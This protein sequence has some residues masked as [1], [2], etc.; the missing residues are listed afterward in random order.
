MI[1]IVISLLSYF[2]PLWRDTS[3][4]AAARRGVEQYAKENYEEAAA[5]LAKAHELRPSPESAFN[6]GTAQIA[7]GKHAQG[8][9]TLEPALKDGKLAADALY[10]RGN[11][12]LAAGAFEYAVRDY[13]HAL[14]LHPGDRRAQRNLEIALRK[15]KEAQRPGAGG[16]DDQ[17]DKGKNERKT[18]STGGNQQQEQPK[19]DANLEAL[20]RSVQQ[21]EQE[22]RQRMKQAGQARERVG[23]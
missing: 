16:Q 1:V 14:K 23:W 13:T 8:S 17:K 12:A 3:S 2:A 4:N 22:E 15:Q 7:A 9:A 11:S 5:S 19:G 18:P 20:L 6:L 10:N 21:Q